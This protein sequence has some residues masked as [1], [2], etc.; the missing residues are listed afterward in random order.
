[1]SLF[2]AGKFNAFWRGEL[3]HR[4][5]ETGKFRG[6]CQA[7][8]SCGIPNDKNSNDK[9]NPNFKVQENGVGIFFRQINL[10]PSRRRVAAVESVWDGGGVGVVELDQ[11]VG[12]GCI[13]DKTLPVEKVRC[14]FD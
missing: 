13:G 1:V 11:A 9:G 7:P 4:R 5:V 10:F 12:V 8:V 3:S 14:G 6:N 2:S